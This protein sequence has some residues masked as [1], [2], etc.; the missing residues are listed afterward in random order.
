MDGS[1]DLKWRYYQSRGGTRSGGRARSSLRGS[2]EGRMMS[3]FVAAGYNSKIPYNSWKSPTD[4]RVP[5]FDRIFS[6]LDI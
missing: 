4:I 1:A 2:P 6:Y 5:R 3:G